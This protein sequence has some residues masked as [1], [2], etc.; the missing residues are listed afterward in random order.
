MNHIIFTAIS[1]RVF[2][3][4]SRNLPPPPVFESK[5]NI[6]QYSYQLAL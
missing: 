1:L 4:C 3:K 2:Y 5:H 6:L